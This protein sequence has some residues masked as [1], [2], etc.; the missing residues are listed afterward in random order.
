MYSQQIRNLKTGVESESKTSKTA[1][2]LGEFCTKEDVNGVKVKDVYGLYRL[3]CAENNFDIPSPQQFGIAMSKKFG[4]KT[5][6]V[7]F[8]DYTCKVF[9]V[10]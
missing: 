6:S 1:D 3:Y 2:T 4:V 7:R 10:N 8:G 5:K 9:F